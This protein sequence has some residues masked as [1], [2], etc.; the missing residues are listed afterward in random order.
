[1]LQ[2]RVVEILTTEM[3]VTGRGFDSKYLALDGQEGD[4]ECTAT[5]VE[6]EDITLVLGLLV[7]TVG[8]SGRSR[9]ID[10]AENFETRNGP[11]V[12]RSETLRVV[13]IGRNTIISV[14][15][16]TE[17]SRHNRLLHS[18]TEFSLGDL[19]HLGENH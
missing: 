13:E 6:D 10:D 16:P 3:S 4:V 17:N 14:V 19:F 5:K 12:F 9:L 11:G 8:N 2:Q 18:L 7:E 1:M 15:S